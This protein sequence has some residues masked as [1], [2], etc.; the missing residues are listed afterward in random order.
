[1]NKCSYID[2]KSQLEGNF[3]QKGK[4]MTPNI[5]LDLSILLP[6]MEA[7]DQCAN[8]LTERL[9][10]EKGIEK[11]HIVREDGSAKLC[12]HY[13]PNLISLAT[14]Q[15][16]AKEA[17]AEVSE[18]YRHEQ[19]SYGRMKTADAA[20]TLESVLQSL[21]GMIHARVNYAAGLIFVAYDSDVL[22]R[23]TIDSVIQRMGSRVISPPAQSEKHEH[24]SEGEHDHGRAPEFLPHWMQ[25]RWTFILVALAGLFYAIGAVG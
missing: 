4:T 22:K 20:R 14:V 1:M 5:R 3:A 11:A 2:T 7:G 17:G 13:D 16:L 12:L 23:E 15:R 19:I 18:R 25:E 21:P 10:H 9:S 24:E 6:Q 8:I